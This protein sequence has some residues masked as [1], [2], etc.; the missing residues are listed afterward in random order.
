MWIYSKSFHVHHLCLWISGSKDRCDLHLGA[1]CGALGGIL[2]YPSITVLEPW[3]AQSSM[4]PCG[5][6]TS[7]K[8]LKLTSINSQDGDLDG[9]SRSRG[10]AMP[11]CSAASALSA[12]APL[13]TYCCSEAAE[14]FIIIACAGGD[15][16]PDGLELLPR[17]AFLCLL[18]T[19]ASAAGPSILSKFCS[20]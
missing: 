15:D 1:L 20:Q 11:I 10:Q 3:I 13:C 4:A 19:S 12:H 8:L 5:R 16:H 7:K 2:S 17:N 9:R 6:A 14:S 18:M